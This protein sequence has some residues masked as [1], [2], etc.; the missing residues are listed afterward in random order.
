M[1]ALILIALAAV[2][3]IAQES[4]PPVQI[5]QPQLKFRD[6][7]LPGRPNPFVMV[8]PVKLNPEALGP[9]LNLLAVAP[10]VCAIPLLRSTPKGNYPIKVVKP[11]DPDPKMSMKNVPAPACVTPGRP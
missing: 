8:N 6:F 11:G 1:K 4:A 2:P 3:L 5:P 10:K 9:K 7:R